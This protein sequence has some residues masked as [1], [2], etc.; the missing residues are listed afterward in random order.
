MKEIC[1]PKPSNVFARYDRNTRSWRTSQVSLLTNTLDEFSGTWPKA[2]IMLDGVCCRQP[3]SELPTKGKGSGLWHTPKTSDSANRD[4][5]RNSRDEPQLAGQVKIYPK[6]E[7][8]TTK[9]QAKAVRSWP[10]PRKSEYKDTGP[11]GSK[12]H[13]HMLGR[14]YLCAKTKDPEQ[15]ISQLNPDWVCW[16]M[17]WPIGWSSLERIKELVW[18]SW[19]VDTADD[20]SIPRVATDIK[21]RVN[22]LKAIGNGQVPQC[23]A[24]VWKLLT[25]P[26]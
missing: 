12:S 5:Y 18:L 25:N 26:S 7:L 16:L 19:E 17:G 23:V 15:P 6:G 8:P 11:G 24:A 4:M 2:G 10:S 3:M 1:G 9:E 21:D 22:R 13:T 20:G 14:A